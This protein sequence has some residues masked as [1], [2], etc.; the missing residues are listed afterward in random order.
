LGD[1]K[2]LHPDV[3]GLIV[4]VTLDGVDVLCQR[5]DADLFAAVGH[6]AIAPKRA[7]P[8]VAVGFDVF[9]ESRVVG[10]PRVEEIGVRRHTYLFFKFGDDLASEIVLDVV[11][12]VVFVLFFLEAGGEWVGGFIFGRRRRR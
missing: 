12:L 5:I 2:L 4:N 10:E 11:I 3:V 7:D 6:F 9:D 1:E 8:V